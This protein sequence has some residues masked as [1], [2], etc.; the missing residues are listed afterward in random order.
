VDGQAV[1]SIPKPVR[2]LAEEPLATAREL[3]PGTHIERIRND[4]F[5]LWIGAVP[6]WNLVQRVRVESADVVDTVEEVRQLLRERGRASAAWSVS[7]SSRPSD[8]EQRLR[9]LGLIPYADPPLE[10]EFTAMAIVHPP[11]GTSVDGVVARAIESY[12]EL[13]TA[14]RILAEAAGV[15]EADRKA[16]EARLDE[17]FQLHES[18]YSR[19]YVAFV[20]GEPAGA[21]RGSLQDAGIY[22]SGGG[23]LPS[24]RGRGAYRALV[25]ARWRDAVARGTPALTVQAGRMSRPIL[26]RLGFT[27]VASILVFCDRFD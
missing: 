8:L 15:S 19:T 25:E 27:T 11:L 17:S 14:T 20:D 4:R 26:E 5:C 3:P 23:V 6:S 12:E 9:R 1:A 22:L 10:P 2:A 24:A 13:S 18:G 7:G 21:A 16:M